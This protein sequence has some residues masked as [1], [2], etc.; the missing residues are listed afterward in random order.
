MPA[1]KDRLVEENLGLVRMVAKRYRGFGVEDEDLIQIGSMGL[2]KAARDFDESKQVRFS[3][4][5]VA[6]IIGEIKTYLRDNGSVK[7]SRKYKEDKFR[8]DRASRDLTQRLG[9]EPRLSE[10]AP[11]EIRQA[12]GE[13]AEATGLRP[14]DILTATEATQQVVSLDLP[15]EE[16][17]VTPSIE[18]P[19]DH[20]INRVLARDILSAL[21]PME[22]RL[23]ILRFF[24]DQTQSAAAAELG[25]SQVAVSR[26][27]KRII[28][29]LKEK[30]KPPC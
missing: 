29:L 13:I 18:S 15:P 7:V 28:N 4:Y 22:R 14:E 26:L 19:E 20:A 21:P 8:I 27:E 6:K 5:A 9:R 3:T 23:I 10:I 17:G 12:A 1:L 11:V 2:I 30:Y 24:Q 16:G 25:L